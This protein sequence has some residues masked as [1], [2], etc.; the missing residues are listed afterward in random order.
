[1][2]KEYNFSDSTKNPY[3]KKLKKQISI[4]LENETVE[5]FKKLASEID[6]PYQNLMNMYLREC[7]QNNFKP[8]IHWQK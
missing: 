5:Y 3:I 7:A 8:N 2:K 6:I 4:R 1:M